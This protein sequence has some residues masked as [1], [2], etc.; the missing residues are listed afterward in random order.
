MARSHTA[1]LKIY[2]ALGRLLTTSQDYG[3]HEQEA[4]QLVEE[5]REL[6]LVA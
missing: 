6:R 1:S 5:F 3:E 4:R 2:L